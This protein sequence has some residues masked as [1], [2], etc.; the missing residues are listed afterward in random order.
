MRND[1]GLGLAAVAAMAFLLGGCSGMNSADDEGASYMAGPSFEDGSDVEGFD[2]P[3]SATYEAVG[4]NPFVITAH[5]P[6]ST[7][8]ADVDTASYDIFRRD[9]EAG[10]LPDPASVRLEEYVNYFD[11]AYPEPAADAEHPFRISLAAAPALFGRD[12]AVMRIGIQA[13]APPA[14]DERRP[15]NLVFLVDTSGSMD[16]AGGLALVQHTLRLTLDELQPTDTV[17]IVTY[18]GSSGVA[19]PPTPVSERETILD[20]IESFSAGGSTAGASGLYLA[21]QQAEVSFIDGGINHVILCTDGDF[22][23]G[24]SST[25]ELVGLIEEKRETGITFTALGFGYGNDAMLEAISNKGNGVYGVMTDERSVERYVGERLLS[26]LTFVAKDM[27]LQVEFNPEQIYAYRLL[28]YENRA[29][30]DDEFR[31]DAIDAGEVGAG[32]RVTALYELVLADQQIP[33]AK[34]APAAVDGAVYDGQLEVTGD[35]LA[36]VRVRY[37]DVDAT[38]TDPAYEVSKTLAVGDIVPL[39][40]DENPDFLWAASVAALAEILKQ[41]PYA[42]PELLPW[43]Q[44]VVARPMYDGDVDRD[45]FEGLVENIASR[46]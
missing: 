7:F 31:D 41:S 34:A 12:T 33:N 35:D 20:E 29:L 40:A 19:L 14:D 27:K 5:D 11:Y 4:T 1:W 21:Y 8:A 46:L 37:K 26:T 39:T 2:D 43:I 32:H 30:A 24:P 22:N 6:L 44:A 28:G 42:D 15:A 9:A 45:E 16:H 17:A 25:E 23:V 13:A 10:R 18:A 36:V 3:S 38:V